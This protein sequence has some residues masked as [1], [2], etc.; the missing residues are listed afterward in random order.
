MLSAANGPIAYYEAQLGQNY[1]GPGPRLGEGEY[2][3]V[4]VACGIEDGCGSETGIHVGGQMRG[5]VADEGSGKMR[6]EG[7]SG[8]T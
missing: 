5:K 7:R 2:D 8:L 6:L 4:K 3:E 1:F